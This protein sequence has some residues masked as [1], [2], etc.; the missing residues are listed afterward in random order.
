MCL[1]ICN[2]VPLL[3]CLFFFKQK[4]AYELRI[5]DWSSDV[6][7]SDLLA[8]HRRRNQP[9]EVGDVNR[10]LGVSGA[11][12]DAPVARDEWEDMAR[13]DEIGL[14][15]ARVNRD[16]NSVGA[17]IRR[18]TRRHP[19]ARLDRHGEGGAMTRAVIL[20]HLLELKK[21]CEFGG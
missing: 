13:C 4:T 3:F 5:S 10:R 20:R 6:C 7:S 8:D 16:R 11:D 12:E 2:V 1:L 17:V 18:Y 14:R 21:A 15:I 9:R 19:F